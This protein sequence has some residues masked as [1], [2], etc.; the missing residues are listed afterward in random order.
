MR[1][2]LAA[3]S[4][5]LVLTALA[6]CS[7]GPPSGDLEAI[8]GP[9]AIEGTIVSTY[10]ARSGGQDVSQVPN[11]PTDRICPQNGVPPGVPECVEASSNYR[12]H[13]MSLPEPTG[14]GYQVFRVG[15]AIGEGKSLTVLQPGANGMWEANVTV[16]ENHDGTFDHFELRL[17]TS[18]TVAKAASASGSQAFVAE[19]ALTAV[20]VTGSYKGSK[21]TLNVQGL[22]EGLKPEPVGRF[23]LRTADG[24]LSAPQE[25]FPVINGEQEYVSK[26]MD[27]GDYAEF[28]IHV[29]ESKVY[30]YQSTI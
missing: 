9:V 24:N 18:F 2:R 22:P 11:A 10:Q 28:H 15:G 21:L 4:A 19:P 5:L 16:E 13:F 17:G 29:G 23:Y 7:D 14:D 6:G 12:I 25:S 30:V 20:T 1:P 26:D 8:P 3:V 27:I